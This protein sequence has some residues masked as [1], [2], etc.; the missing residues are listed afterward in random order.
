MKQIFTLVC[1]FL[2]AFLLNPYKGF[3]QPVNTHRSFTWDG[4]PANSVSQPNFFA[5][6]GPDNVQV[7]LAVSFS[8]IASANPAKTFTYANQ[9]GRISS[10]K[11]EKLPGSEDTMYAA[12]TFNKNLTGFNMDINPFSSTYVVIQAYNIAG[13]RVAVK[14]AYDYLTDSVPRK[15]DTLINNSNRD[16]HIY[17]NGPVS[18]VT[19]KVIRNN[20]ASNG[21]EFAVGAASWFN[22][23]A[24]TP[25]PDLNVQCDGN[26][27]L[28]ILDASTSID[29]TERAELIGAV[30]S[31]LN[32]LQY[33][34]VTPNYISIVEFC[35]QATLA[36]PVTMVTPASIAT[37]GVIYNYL[38][39]TN[40]NGYYSTNALYGGQTNWSQA[41]KVALDQARVKKPNLLIFFTDGAPN[42]VYETNVASGVNFLQSAAWG[43][44]RTS[45]YADTIK[46]MGTHLLGVGTD[47][48]NITTQDFYF[49]NAIEMVNPVIYDYLTP[50]PSNIATADYV[51][52]SAFPYLKQV[53]NNLFFSCLN[54]LPVN[55]SSIQVQQHNC[56]SNTISW[57]MDDEEGGTYYAVE[58]STDGSRFNIIGRVEKIQAIQKGQYTF[59]DN[60]LDARTIYYRI[61]AV[62]TSGHSIFSKVVTVQNSC[63]NNRLAIWPNPVRSDKLNIRLQSQYKG[64]LQV[65]VFDMTGRLVL[66]KNLTKNNGIIEVEENVS[67]LP[68]G[69]YSLRVSDSQHH[70][71]FKE[72]FVKQ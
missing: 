49:R 7:G 25:N 44:N 8:G 1:I 39:N 67:G 57:K 71:L 60:N 50:P 62:S 22:A 24:Y 31:M 5:S 65:T 47:K 41:F 51:S 30:E 63:L 32:T 33:Y 11:M 14:G 40:G 52:V 72:K 19:Y 69:V 9:S 4:W 20:A 48:I 15:G 28:L 13:S 27:I 37:G 64:L 68:A 2:I 42:R 26:Q 10:L 46:Q 59:E 16:V 66:N 38:H 18:K 56:I 17:F 35:R 29:A 61:K 55:F 70:V 58:K 3:S 43:I 45:L 6:L 23:A 34:A 36:L 53:F 54:Y 12:L 21:M